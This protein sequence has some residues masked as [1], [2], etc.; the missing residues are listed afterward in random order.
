MANLFP[1]RAEAAS[2]LQNSSG[3]YEPLASLMD[4]TEAA[5]CAALGLRNVRHRAALRGLNNMTSVDIARLLFEVIAA[6]YVRGG[7]TANKDRSQQNWRWC[8]IQSQ[9]GAA[10]R[11]PEVVLERAVAASCLRAGRVDWGNQ[12]PVASGLIRGVSDR[13]RAIDL[14][15]R[16]GERHFEFIELKIASD[17]PLYAAIEIIGYACIWLLA[18][19]DRPSRPSALLD[20]DQVDLRVLAPAAFYGSHKLQAIESRLDQSSSALGE[21]HG[22]TLTFGF[23]VLD[24]RLSESPLPADDALLSLLAARQ[25]L[26]S[27]YC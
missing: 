11:S 10:N 20:A 18:R 26:S 21:R 4:H 13:R 8:S 1:I 14:V 7:A 15:H 5:V 2:G 23:D 19:G 17:T 25:P 27:L 16:R 6:N 3:K 9:I 22:V 24:D 12:V